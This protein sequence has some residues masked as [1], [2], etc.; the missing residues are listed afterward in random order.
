MEHTQPERTP[1]QP[2]DP[3]AILAPYALPPLDLRAE[4]VAPF[5][6]PDTPHARAELG[7]V[8]AH[9]ERYVYAERM[10]RRTTPPQDA[11]PGPVYLEA[12]GALDD[13]RAELRTFATAI[14]VR[15]L[16]A[17]CGY[18]RSRSNP[19]ADEARAE[20][21]LR[22]EL[23]ALDLATEKLG[24]S[25]YRVP[26]NPN[27]D[28]LDV[29]D[30]ERHGTHYAYDPEPA[31]NVKA[32]MDFRGVDWDAVRADLGLDAG[33]LAPTGTED[34]DGEPVV[35]PFGEEWIEAR[36][37][38][39]AGGPRTAQFYQ[40]P[41]SFAR[42]LAWEDGA[43]RVR[44]LFADFG[45]P[46]LVSA[47]RQ[48]GWACVKGLLD[49]RELAEQVAEDAE[50]FAEL[51]TLRAKHGPDGPGL[52]EDETERRAELEEW[53]E[54]EGEDARERAAELERFL[55]A[56]SE[57]QA[58][59]AAT[60]ADFP[61]QVAWHCA[62]IFEQEAQ[63][64]AEELARVAKVRAIVAERVPALAG[65]A[66]LEDADPEELETML[67]R[68]GDPKAPTPELDTDW[69]AAPWTV[70]SDDSLPPA[71][72]QD[73]EDGLGVL[74]CAQ[75]QSSEVLRYVCDLHNATLDAQRADADVAYNDGLDE[76]VS[77]GR[78][79]T[80][81]DLAPVRNAV[82][83]AVAASDRIADPDAREGLRNALRIL[84]SL[85]A[86]TPETDAPDDGN[87]VCITETMDDKWMIL[88]HGFQTG[89]DKDLS[90]AGSETF[91]TYEEAERVAV[92][93]YGFKHGEPYATWDEERKLLELGRRVVQELRE[94]SLYKPRELDRDGYPI[95]T[96]LGDGLARDGFHALHDYA[97]ELGVLPVKR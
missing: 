68:V 24:D 5:L 84:D 50:S 57:W 80:A 90:G 75:G 11:E 53:E 47:G 54:Q 12:S 78:E 69:K 32:H 2:A 39:D 86:P 97:A 85:A 4:D 76:G 92:E 96:V 44:E 82:E 22:A 40:G 88:V 18:L 23:E 34:E 29:E 25:S 46:E 77:I 89:D 17:V 52:D 6:H 38:L 62:Q 49:Y 14:G 43:E 93:R 35:L 73:T 91:D 64:Y 56:W 94:R 59:C 21:A 95:R 37:D 65:L 15:A 13:A 28:A 72:I 27:P 30:I 58:Y 31:V 9:A 33:T 66:V 26:A 16:R 10:I 67:A 48:G 45:R 19:D 71:I 74:E 8:L 63:E 36:W 60:V 51:E 87:G 7:A 55:G 83:Y 20:D 61:S 1:E 81:E 41:E 79:T 70:D 42:E 3:A